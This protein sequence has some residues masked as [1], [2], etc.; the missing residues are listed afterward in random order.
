MVCLGILCF[1]GEG[2][3]QVVGCHFPLPHAHMPEEA[4]KLSRFLVLRGQSLLRPQNL[5]SRVPAACAP[6]C[7]WDSKPLTKAKTEVGE[8]LGVAWS[9]VSLV[10]NSL[11]KILLLMS[12]GGGL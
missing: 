12:Y 7:C 3:L 9:C 5:Q 10:L 11:G 8:G 2:R 6:M 4:A 1:R